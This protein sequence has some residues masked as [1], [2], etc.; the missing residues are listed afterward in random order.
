MK[1]GMVRWSVRGAVGLVFV[2]NVAC[3]L[4][5]I[6]KPEL[7][8]GGFE[9]SGAPGEIAVQG[10]GILFLMWNATYPPVI[11]RPDAHRTLFAVILAQQV[12]GLVGESWLFLTLPPEYT[13]LHATGLRFILFDG[14]GLLFL[15]AAYVLSGKAGASNETGSEKAT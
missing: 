2:V 14:L 6:L 11:V 7:Y 9:L 8:V 15:S 3:A 1:V 13:L 5:F 4:D 10:F 12:I